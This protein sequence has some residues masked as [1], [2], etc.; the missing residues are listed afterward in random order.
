[1]LAFGFKV[2]WFTLSLLGFLSNILALPAFA[3]ALD[4]YLIPVFYTVSNFL[5]QGIFCLGMIWKMDPLAMPRAFCTVQPVIFTVA[6]L[7]MTFITSGMAVC[8]TSAIL[9]PKGGVPAT[10]TFVRSRIQWHAT[11]LFLALVPMA[12]SGAYLGLALKFD[13]VQ[14]DDGMSC[15]ATHPVWV[16]LFS[17]AGVPLLLALPSLVLTCTAGYQFY[18]H[19]P[20]QHHSHSFGHTTDHFTSVPLRRQSRTKANRVY[21]EAKTFDPTLWSL[22]LSPTLTGLPAGQRSATPSSTI[23]VEAIPSPPDSLSS[24]RV[25]IIAGR[26]PTVSRHDLRYHLPFQWRFNEPLNSEDGFRSSP[27]SSLNLSRSHSRHTPSPLIFANPVEERNEQLYTTT[28]PVALG[29][30]ESLYEAAPWLKDEKAYLRQ[31]EKVK[32]DLA[33]QPYPRNANKDPNHVNDEGY[34]GIS[35]SLRWARHSDGSIS[36]A[37]SVLEFARGPRRDDPEALR[38]PSPVELST[39]DAALTETPIPDFTYMVWRILF[40][41]LLSSAAQIVATLSSLVD[42]SKQHNPPAPFGTQHV[43]LL[44]VAWLPLVSFGVRWPWWWRRHAR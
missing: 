14:P 7:F 11:C 15:D 29:P 40:F 37:K 9:R 33:H 5:L 26:A 3:E 27:D 17:Y 25:R 32:P 10:P 28:V 34:D 20:H 42:M 12:A 18:A 13:A 30:S 8:S 16:R 23:V 44:L 6:W 35:R 38:R 19:S 39:Y 22:E 1:M 41:Q 24:G 36:S 4:G 43:A 31:M 2:A 21:H